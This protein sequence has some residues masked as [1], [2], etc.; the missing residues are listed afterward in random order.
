MKKDLETILKNTQ[1]KE[2]CLEWKGCLNTDGYA[3]ALIDGDANA[4]VHRI[5]FELS[6]PEEDIKGFLVRHTCDNP[7]CINPSH[8]LKGTPK[9]NGHDKF[10]RNRQPKKLTKELILNV[11][12]LLE[13]KLLTQ[14][15][16]ANSLGIDVRRVSEINCNKFS[17]EGKRIRH[18]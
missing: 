6:H 17:D 16:I 2:D 18:G 1:N 3:R 15:T 13:T 14:A 9:E 12:T 4:K 8:L 11:K 7:K 5:V 10:V